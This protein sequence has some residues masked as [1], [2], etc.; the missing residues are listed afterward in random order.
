[1][2]KSDLIRQIINKTEGTI[3]GEY[4]YTL[5]NFNRIQLELILLYSD[6]HQLYC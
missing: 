2:K 6:S 4:V 1:M 5:A 3:T